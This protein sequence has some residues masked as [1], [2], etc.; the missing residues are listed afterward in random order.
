[1][2]WTAVVV[3][4]TQKMRVKVVLFGCL[5][6]S[7]A[8]GGGEDNVASAPAWSMV[9]DGGSQTESMKDGNDFTPSVIF[10]PDQHHR[11]LIQADLEAA[12]AV[13]S[14]KGYDILLLNASASEKSQLVEQAIAGLAASRSVVI[15][16]DGSQSQIAIVSAVSKQVAGMGLSVAAVSIRQVQDGAI[17]VTPI[18]TEAAYRLRQAKEG[19]SVSAGNTA[20]YAL[21]VVEP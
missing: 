15:D 17:A 20:R 4:I 6:V 7:S 5:L 19:K 14:D 2:G 9:T 3:S 18:E 12:G 10:A 1:M 11:G 21:G 13:F 8:C 16:S